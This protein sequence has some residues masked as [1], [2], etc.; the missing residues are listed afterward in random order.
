MHRL[1]SKR[2]HRGFELKAL[3]GSDKDETG[4]QARETEKDVYFAK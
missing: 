4:V 3:S 1:P 2:D